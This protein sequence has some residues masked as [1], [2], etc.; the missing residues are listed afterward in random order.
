MQALFAVVV[1]MVGVGGFVANLRRRQRPQREW[2]ST[3]LGL[4]RAEYA[5]HA[6][7]KP[8][9]ALMGSRIG[10]VAPL[11]LS[12]PAAGRPSALR[13]PDPSRRGA[14]RDRAE[15]RSLPCRESLLL[16]EPAL[17]DRHAAE[18][19][20]PVPDADLT[21]IRP[22]EWMTVR[23]VCYETRL[24][25]T[26]IRKQLRLEALPYV[27]FGH[28]IRIRRSEYEIWSAKREHPVNE[29]PGR[30]GQAAS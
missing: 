15:G 12:G 22:P 6:N 16:N 21:G 7:L 25:A 5:A 20:T 11:R 23:E 14:G 3:R 19:G 26:Y 27:N 9:P 1:G 24:S 17:N 28:R 8:Q 10:R 2:A 18:P 13:R 29:L 4:V 30:A